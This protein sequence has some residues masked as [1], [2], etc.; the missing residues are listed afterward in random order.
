VGERHLR[1]VLHEQ[2]HTIFL[3]VELSQGRL[4]VRTN[5][6]HDL[7][8]Q[9]ERLRVE[10]ATAVPGVEQQSGVKVT[11][12]VATWPSIRLWF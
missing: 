2:M 12:E 11:G 6:G 7:F 3:S 10:H 4:E 5:L 9:V 1:R 8:T